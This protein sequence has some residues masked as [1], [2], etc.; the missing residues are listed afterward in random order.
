MQKRTISL[1]LGVTA[2]LATGFV[3]GLYFGR[4]LTDIHSRQQT[5]ACKEVV[6][7]HLRDEGFLLGSE[8]FVFDTL[9]LN[10]ETAS[11]TGMYRTSEPDQNR[12]GR[13]WIELTPK[14]G[15]WNPTSVMIK[16]RADSDS[17]EIIWP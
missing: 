6:I 13:F 12:V 15:T 5:N 16:S 1:V 8:H 4:N 3:A 9:E 2:A 7:Q 10:N 14:A 11:F 17:E